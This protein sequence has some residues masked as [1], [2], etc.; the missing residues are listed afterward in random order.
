MGSA[1]DI[2]NLSLDIQKLGHKLDAKEIN[3]GEKWHDFAGEQFDEATKFIDKIE[4]SSQ[5]SS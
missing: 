5:Q 3:S 4:K 1:A 2:W